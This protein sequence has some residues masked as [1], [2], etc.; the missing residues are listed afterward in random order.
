MLDGHGV[1]Q[2]PDLHIQDG[3]AR[4]LDGGADLREGGNI[5]PRKDMAAYPGIGAAGLRAPADGM[6]QSHAIWLEQPA[7]GPEIAFV[8][9]S[10]HV[11]EHADADDGVIASLMLAV[12]LGQ[13][14][15][16]LS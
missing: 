14:M 4:C 3:Q 11:L 5:T 15:Y 13:E 8:P 9:R 10:S 12:I 1:M 2:S 16:L 6:H 7:D